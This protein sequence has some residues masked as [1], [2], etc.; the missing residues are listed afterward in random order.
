[1][2]EITL[3]SLTK[4]FA[5]TA[6]LAEAKLVVHFDCPAR[7]H[8][9]RFSLLKPR[10]MRLSKSQKKPLK[11]ETLSS[12]DSGV[13]GSATLHREEEE[14]LNRG[15]LIPKNQPSASVRPFHPEECPIRLMSR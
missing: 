15:A 9:N 11:R 7:G 12:E 13:P 10:L 3:L 4:Q 2:T 14:N 8:S 5:F 1:V 6:F